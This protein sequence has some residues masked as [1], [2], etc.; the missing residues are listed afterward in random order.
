M[1]QID[2]TRSFTPQNPPGKIDNR[3]FACESKNIEHIVLADFLSAKCNELIEHRFRVAQTAFGSTCNR[4]RGS[5]L[6]RNF[7]LSSDELQMFRDQVCRNAGQIKQLATT[8]NRRENF[9]RLGGREDEFHMLGRFFEG[10]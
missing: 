5:G 7:L 8:Q 10:L 3:L 1:Q 2:R 9:L 4:M 6:K